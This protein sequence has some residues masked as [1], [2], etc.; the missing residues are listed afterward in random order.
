[1][2]IFF[3]SGGGAACSGLLS[4]IRVLLAPVDDDDYFW[5]LAAS[6]GGRD[7]SWTSSGVSFLMSNVGRVTK[8]ANILAFCGG[9]PV[10][11]FAMDFSLIL[12]LVSI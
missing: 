3:F 4:S 6:V 10:L 11:I 2:V 8:S 1:M 9:G 7:I 5:G 12:K